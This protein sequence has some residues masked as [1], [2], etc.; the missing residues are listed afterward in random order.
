MH[1]YTCFWEVTLPFVAMEHRGAMA[2]WLDSERSKTIL[3]DK[4][5]QCANFTCFHAGPTGGWTQFRLEPPDVLLP[6][7]RGRRPRVAAAPAN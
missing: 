3:N 5:V 2:N 4:T 1:A 6:A 7:R